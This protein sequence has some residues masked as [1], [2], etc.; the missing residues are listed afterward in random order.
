VQPDGLQERTY[1]EGNAVVLERR[2][3]KEGRETIYRRVNHPWGAVVYFED[4]LA[5]PARRWAEVFGEP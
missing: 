4:G 5:I 2:L 3:V 1:K